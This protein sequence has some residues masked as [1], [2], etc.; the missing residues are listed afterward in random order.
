MVP[1]EV[2][3][4]EERKKL[5]TELVKYMSRELRPRYKEVMCNFYEKYEN[6]YKNKSSSSSL[7]KEKTKPK[8]IKQRID[9][10]AK[11]R[12]DLKKLAKKQ[13]IDNKIKGKSK[14]KEDV[15]E[16]EEVDETGDQNHD[17]DK[18]CVVCYKTKNLYVSK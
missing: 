16:S 10:I 1:N 5:S 9:E 11:R 6:N 12:A 8:D 15:K 13:E 3:E 17:P 4:Y 18:S 14:E 7:K 2:P